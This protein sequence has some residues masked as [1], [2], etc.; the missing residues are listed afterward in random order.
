METYIN[1]YIS[2]TAH[3][4]LSQAVRGFCVL[5]AY[6]TAYQIAYF[7]VY[8]LRNFFLRSFRLGRIF[9]DQDAQSFAQYETQSWQ[10]LQACF[11]NSAQ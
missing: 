5:S 7:F 4:R 2:P 8:R 9:A 11:L 3:Q 6:Q 1:L 10:D